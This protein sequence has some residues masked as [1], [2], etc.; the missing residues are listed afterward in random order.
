MCRGGQVGVWLALFFVCALSWACGPSDDD[1]ENIP[2]NDDP[3]EIEI[4]ID[5]EGEVLPGPYTPEEIQAKLD[6]FSWAETDPWPEENT[7]G[8]PAFYY[9]EM[10]VAERS[11]EDDLSELGVP[12]DYL[13]LFEEELGPWEGD[14]SVVTIDIAAIEAGRLV[15]AVIPGAFINVIREAAL[16]GD[17]S[18]RFILAREA[19]E[20]FL[21]PDGALDLQRLAEAGLLNV[22]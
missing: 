5:G 12:F 6:A 20:V 14:S 22:L 13:P 1:G 8:E 7:S 18:V 9:V 15:F 11:T 17:P 16:E 21:R 4:V 10:L 19:P 3:I 2:E